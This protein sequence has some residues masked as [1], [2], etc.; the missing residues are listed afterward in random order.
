[1]ILN[2]HTAI[3]DDLAD[4]LDALSGLETE[5][6][7]IGTNLRLR[8]SAL[9][10]IEANNSG[11][12]SRLHSAMTEWLRLNYND[13][14]K[15]S[16]PSWR[17]LA[18]AVYRLD[19]RVFNKITREHP[20]TYGY[21]PIVNDKLAKLQWKGTLNNEIKYPEQPDLATV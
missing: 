17:I 4:V 6:R 10:T 19:M 2:I 15:D 1:M 3:E 20:G 8:N 13:G 7:R 11:V 5:W 16:F 12:Q 14:N 18:K 9:D 21:Y